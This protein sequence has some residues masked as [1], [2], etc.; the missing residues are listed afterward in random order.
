M[1]NAQTK[2]T[3]VIIVTINVSRT[4]MDQ[5]LKNVD[6]LKERALFISRQLG[7]EVIGLRNAI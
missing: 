3:A 4:S 6:L 2:Q 5:L 1:I 7:Y